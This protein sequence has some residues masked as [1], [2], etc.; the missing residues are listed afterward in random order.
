MR[1]LL[2]SLM[3]PVLCAA[4]SPVIAIDQPHFDFGRISGEGKAVHRFKVTNKGSAPLNISRLNPSCGC[5]STVIGQWTLNPGESTEV[6]ATFNPTGMHGLVHKSI[7]VVSND[8]ANA[9]VNLT[10]EA[11]VQREIMP[12]TESIFFQDVIR[13]IPGKVSVKFTS[14]SGAPV[15]LT[16]AKAPG[17]PYLSA[18]IR[19]EGKEPWVDIVMDGKL[20]PPGRTVGTD[21][22]VVRTT[23]AKAPLINITVQW[24]MRSSLVTDPERIAWQEPAG[25]ELRKKVTLKQVDGKPFRILSAKTT[26]P[27][28]LKVEGLGHTPSAQQDFQVVLAASARAG[29]YTEKV[30][31]VTDNPDQPEVEFRVAALLR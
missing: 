6:E 11:D 29:M 24:V 27:A 10:L 19:N 9:T 3:V 31:L 30:L 25:K 17:A 12:S 26:N 5:T 8:P 20:V 16:E 21:A 4:Q 13:T 22:V 14:G 2:F 1:T 28:V 7:Q 18:T 23:S 15:V